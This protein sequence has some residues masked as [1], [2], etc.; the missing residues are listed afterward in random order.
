MTKKVRWTNTCWEDKFKNHIFLSS[1]S[2][3]LCVFMYA[4]E[5]VHL[6]LFEFDPLSGVLWIILSCRCFFA[7]PWLPAVNLNSL[8][9]LRSAFLA[10]FTIF[11][12]SC[13][14]FCWLCYSVPFWVVMQATVWD[15]CHVLAWKSQQIDLY[16][17]CLESRYF[18]AQG[19]HT[20]LNLLEY[21]NFFQG[22]NT[23]LFCFHLF[24][25]I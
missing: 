7:R 2:V 10:I 25:I 24:L 11:S 22:I 14:F 13:I 6:Y 5:L 8:L 18:R 23:P 16:L 21:F 3:F 20:R 9:A 17:N 15:F 12:L 4:C 1:F 19:I